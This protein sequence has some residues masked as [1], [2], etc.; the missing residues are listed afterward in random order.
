MHSFEIREF[1]K[2]DI[3]LIRRE[4]VDGR[5]GLPPVQTSILFMKDNEI[6]DLIEV[7]KVYGKQG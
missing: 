5:E 1:G 2:D 6:L 7:L 4:K 3:M